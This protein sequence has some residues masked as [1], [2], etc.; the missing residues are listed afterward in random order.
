MR[1]ARRVA[2]YAAA[3]AAPASLPAPAWGFGAGD[4]A[5]SALEART[6]NTAPH[7]VTD[8]ILYQ[9]AIELLCRR[10][11]PRMRLRA[12]MLT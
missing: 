1:I 10:V 6:L 7:I 11:A 2:S 9:R 5:A 4:V 8:A 12:R 3:A